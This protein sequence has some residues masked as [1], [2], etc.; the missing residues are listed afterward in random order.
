MTLTTSGLPH[1][2]VPWPPNRGSSWPRDR[3]QVSCIAGR[4]F[5]KLQGKPSLD[6]GRFWGKSPGFNADAEPQL[7][8]EKSQT[9]PGLSLL[10][11]AASC[12]GFTLW[13]SELYVVHHAQP[14]KSIS[15][16]FS[17]SP[18]FQKLYSIKINYKQAIEILLWS[19][20]LLIFIFIVTENVITI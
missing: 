13:R 19:P 16:K 11:H 9:F 3:T 15:A 8:Q 10:S 18:H 12:L 5:T 4:F 2:A 7:S 17:L 14:G 6:N 20:L 1:G